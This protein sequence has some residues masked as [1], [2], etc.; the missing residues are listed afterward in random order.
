[1]V[2]QLH[3][4]LKVRIPFRSKNQ[5][6]KDEKVNLV[7]WGPPKGQFIVLTVYKQTPVLRKYVKRDRIVKDG[8]KNIKKVKKKK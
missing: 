3:L 8:A 1:M 5:R 4:Q 2:E 7:Q 6:R